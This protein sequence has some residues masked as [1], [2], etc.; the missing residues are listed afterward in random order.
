VS[1]KRVASDPTRI[2]ASRFTVA[3]YSARYIAFVRTGTSSIQQKHRQTRDPDGFAVIF[4]CPIQITFI[5]ERFR[6]VL[7]RDWGV[8]LEADGFVVVL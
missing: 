6:S 4:Y 3:L 7:K 5:S 1:V 8:I 2:E